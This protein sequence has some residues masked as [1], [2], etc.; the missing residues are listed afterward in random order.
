MSKTALLVGATGLVGGQLLRQ[1]L[2]SPHYHRV[3]VLARRPMLDNHPKLH[4]VV[5][6]F[7]KPDAALVQGDDVFCALGT[8]LAKAGSKSAQ[9]QID[10]VYPASIG[11]LARANGAQRYLL[12]SSVGADA[13]SSNFYLKTKGDLEQQVAAM[14]FERFVAARPSFLLGQR[15]EF[16]LGERVGIAVARLL[17]PLLVGSFKKYRGIEAAQVAAALLRFAND[18]QNGD[19]VAEYEDLVG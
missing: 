10:C 7:A 11:Q 8:T 12:V 5:F 15:A 18:G 9:Y 6:D 16:R 19:L 3:T 1:L 17:G 14:G 2:D 4:S 13:A